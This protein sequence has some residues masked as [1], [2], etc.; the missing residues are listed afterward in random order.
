MTDKTTT[1]KTKNNNYKTI[2]GKSM[3]QGSYVSED[4][5]NLIRR[6][7][8]TLGGVP[9]LDLTNW[10]TPTYL[11]AGTTQIR[12]LNP[13]CHS[14]TVK[15]VI[16]VTDSSI[17]I[18]ATMGPPT[19]GDCPVPASCPV[20]ITPLQYVNMYASVNALVAQIGVEITFQYVLN[21][22]PT[23][24][25]RIV[26]LLAGTNTVWAFPDTNVKYAPDTTLV[27]YGAEVTK[28]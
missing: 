12:S 15:N 8:Q 26:D 9:V 13:S 22:L 10:Q 4:T 7:Q 1:G 25:P 19:I 27:L 18:C 11:P 14:I 28:Y 16:T 6:A 3:T 2:G 23:A 21:D 24:T 17:N 5:N 20:S